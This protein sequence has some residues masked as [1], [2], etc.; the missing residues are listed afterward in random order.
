MGKEGDS[1]LRYREA[2][3][4]RMTFVDQVDSFPLPGFAGTCLPIRLLGHGA[5]RRKKL[6]ALPW[7]QIFAAVTFSRLTLVQGNFVQMH[8]ENVN[9][10]K[11]FTK[12]EM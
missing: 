3:E 10:W 4:A 2:T 5:S 8:V 7:Q 9:F 11:H 12:F 1:P 6:G